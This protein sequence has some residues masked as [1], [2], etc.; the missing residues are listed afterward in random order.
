MCVREASICA[1]RIKLQAS[2]ELIFGS[3]EIPVVPKQN[4]AEDRMALGERIV[5]LDSLQRRVSR[6]LS[7]FGHPT[8]K[9]NSAESISET[10]VGESVTRVKFDRLLEI[11]DAFLNVGRSQFEN[12]KTSRHV[13]LIGGNAFRMMLFDFTR[14]RKQ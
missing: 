11:A 2:L 3:C 8:D 12:V 10:R 5:D 6:L 1:V 13:E 9:R 4:R 7:E 14:E